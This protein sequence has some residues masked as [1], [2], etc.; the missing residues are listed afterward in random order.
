MGP[1]VLQGRQLP[2][3]EASAPAS[4]VSRVLRLVLLVALATGFGLLWVARG[5]PSDQL[6]IFAWLF[7]VEICWNITR[8]PAVHLWFLRDWAPFML[9]LLAYQYSAGFAD[10]LGVPVHITGTIDADRLLFAGTV[11]TL[12]L[13]HHLYRPGHVHWYDVIAAFVYFSHFVASLTVAVVLWL[14]RRS[15]WVC[16]VRRLLTLSLL[17]LIGYVVYPSAPPWWAAEHGYLPHVSRITTIGWD[18]LG[19]RVAPQLFEHGQAQGNQLAAIPSLHAAFAALIAV[20]FWRRVRRPWRLLL[21]TYPLAMAVVLV[22]CGEHYVVDILTGWAALAVALLLVNTAERH[23]S[24]SSQPV[25]RPPRHTAT[26]DSSLLSTPPG[27]YRQDPLGD[28]PGKP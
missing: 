18:L 20:F 19:L 9:A 26:P 10:D 6:Q 3:A 1:P 25:S 4:H 13:Q 27:G 23:L 12:W 16:Y 14:R 21:A 2:I 24:H 28:P 17:G 7:A 15:L 11:P 5:L 22:Y 8:P